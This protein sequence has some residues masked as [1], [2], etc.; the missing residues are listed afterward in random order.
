ML[1][2]GLSIGFYDTVDSLFESAG[3]Y[4]LAIIALLFTLPETG[5]F[6]RNEK[7]VVIG[8]IFM[9]ALLLVLI[10]APELLSQIILW[11]VLGIGYLTLVVYDAI[12]SSKINGKYR[13]VLFYCNFFYIFHKFILLVQLD[14]VSVGQ[15]NE[16]SE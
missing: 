9:L 15:A 6:T 1:I 2:N 3:A 5:A 8:S 7:A 14:A 12:S 4:F 11:S 16:R 13:N 10:S